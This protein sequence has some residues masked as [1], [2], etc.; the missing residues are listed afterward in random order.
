V[1]AEGRSKQGQSAIRGEEADDDNHRFKRDCPPDVVVDVVAELVRQDDLDLVIGVLVQHGVGHEY[2]PRVTQSRQ[3]RIGLP[4]PG[5]EY[6]RID[7]DDARA[8]A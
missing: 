3:R 6:P 2:P 5:A 8:G 1:Q 4:C 7:A